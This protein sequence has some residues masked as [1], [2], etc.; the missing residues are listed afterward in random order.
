MLTDTDRITSS[1]DLDDY[2]LLAQKASTLISPFLQLAL[3]ASHYKA[4]QTII[5][6]SGILWATYCGHLI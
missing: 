4:I 5:T 3:F 2:A 6:T 1:L